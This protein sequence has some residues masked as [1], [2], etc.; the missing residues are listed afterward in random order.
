M[1]RPKCGTL[2]QRDAPFSGAAITVDDRRLRGLIPYGVES[3]DLGGWTE[4]VEPGALRNADT[5]EL[6]ATVDH[7]GMPLGRLS[8]GT[9]S[10]EDGANGYGWSVELPESR[11]DVREAVERGDIVGGSWRMIVG[12]DHWVGDVRHID[13]IRELRDVCV[14]GSHSPAYPAATVEYRTGGGAGSTSDA[15]SAPGRGTGTGT[16]NLSVR[17]RDS[18]PPARG[19]AE[20]FRAHGFPD[21]V[22]SIT[23]EEFRTAVWSGS[24]DG[25]AKERREAAALGYDARYAWPA[26][27]RVA[28]D[29]GVT[30]V[31]VLTQT[32]RSLASTATVI[33]AIDSVAAKPESGSTMA[34]VGTPL[35]QLATICTAIPN[36][37]LEQRAFNTT[38][39]NDL[40]AALNDAL[41]ALLVTAV[42]ASGFQTPLANMVL[43]VRAAITTLRAAGYNP[44]TVVL[45]PAADEALDVLVSGIASG[46]ADFVF[47]PGQFSPGTI[48]G[49]ARRVSK[50]VAA[51]I[52]MDSGAFG[53]LYASPVALARF[54]NASGTTNTSNVRMELNAQVGVERQTAAVRIAAS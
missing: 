30:S 2:E 35:K 31:D 5:S 22:A 41:D 49:C 34:L 9:L 10:V 13:E 12:R 25:L 1:N 54:E 17:D 11:A 26:L 4:V 50:T 7:A 19:L 47:S 48:F 46:T 37:Y 28:V 45:T 33:R 20:E 42:A 3:R 32:A 29:A 27:G 18:A 15:D 52:V 53:K 8:S 24:V 39:E 16:G 21:E 43:S 44:N 40:R 36:L 23:F 51:P 6:I 38:I 14:A